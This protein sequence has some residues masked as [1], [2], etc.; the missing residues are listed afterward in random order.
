MT[1]RDLQKGFSQIDRLDYFEMGIRGIPLVSPHD[2]SSIGEGNSVIH[3][4]FTEKYFSISLLLSIDEVIRI[5][6]KYNSKN[7]PHII[8]EIRVVEIHLPSTPRRWE[9]PEHQDLSMQWEKRRKGMGFKHVD[10]E[11][12]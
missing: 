5:S 9:A 10:I 4:E 7:P 6:E 3:E 1:V 8:L 11:Y 12:L 2:T